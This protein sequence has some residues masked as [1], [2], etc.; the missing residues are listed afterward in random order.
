MRD[1]GNESGSGQLRDKAA[2]T[3][4][5]PTRGKQ[6]RAHA[7]IMLAKKDLELDGRSGVCVQCDLPPSLHAV[8]VPVNSVTSPVAC[9]GASKGARMAAGVIRRA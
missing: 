1:E 8:T 7:V 6:L 5:I 3:R 4:S 9:F 2:Q